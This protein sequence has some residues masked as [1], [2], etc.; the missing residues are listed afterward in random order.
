MEKK[1]SKDFGDEMERKVSRDFSSDKA[2]ILAP[3]SRGKKGRDFGDGMERKKG[4]ILVTGWR[5]KKE[6]HW[7]RMERKKGRFWRR[8]GEE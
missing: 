2:K 6:R 8:N 7:R 3:N 1:K 4:E 5:G